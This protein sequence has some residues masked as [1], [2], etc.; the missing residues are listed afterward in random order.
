MLFSKLTPNHIKT[1]KATG[2]ALQ[3][4]PATIHTICQ[5]SGRG[6]GGTVPPGTAD[7]GRLRNI[8]NTFKEQDF[9]QESGAK[10]KH[11]AIEKYGL[12][13]FALKL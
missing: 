4:R 1:A 7:G 9:I 5:F 11:E 3:Q 10:L 8:E 6:D 13:D 2:P 12:E